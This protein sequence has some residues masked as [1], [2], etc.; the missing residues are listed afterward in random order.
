MNVLLEMLYSICIL[1]GLSLSV[2]YYCGLK[3][4]I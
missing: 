2:V 3:K 4:I 1:G